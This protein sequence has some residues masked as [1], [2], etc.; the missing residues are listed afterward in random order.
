M[1]EQNDL[2]RIN[3]GRGP[4]LI[5]GDKPAP[6]YEDEPVQEYWHTVAL[7]ITNI[8]TRARTNLWKLCANL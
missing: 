6:S 5:Y 7:I 8:W 4:A 2:R 3:H 1:Y